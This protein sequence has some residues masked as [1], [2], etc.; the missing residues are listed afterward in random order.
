[1]VHGIGMHIFGIKEF[2]FSVFIK[3]KSQVFVIEFHINW[4]FICLKPKH[5]QLRR[6]PLWC[7]DLAV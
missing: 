6:N 5:C 7:I 2:Q 3:E 1:M 4:Y